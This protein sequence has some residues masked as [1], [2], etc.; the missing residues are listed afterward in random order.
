MDGQ[1]E[2][3]QVS[4]ERNQ[5]AAGADMVMKMDRQTGTWGAVRTFLSVCFSVGVMALAS[6]SNGTT[7]AYPAQT[8]STNPLAV[9]QLNGA[10]SL[11]HDPTIIR[12][13]STYYVLSTD[14]GTTNGQVG[15]LPILCSTDQI[16]WTR[17]GQV[18]N[19]IPSWI[20]SQ[21]S[22]ISTLWAPDVS[23]FNGLYHVYYVAS[24]FGTN[25]SVIGLATATTM[26]GP[27]TDYGSAI[28]QSTSSSYYNAIDPN[29]L[30]D[31]GS[32]TT[33]QHVW[34]TFGSFYGGIYQREINPATGTLLATNTTMYQLA[35]RPAVSGNPIEGASLVQKNGYYY[36][37][38]SFGYCCNS[39][40]TTDTYQI[41]VGRGSSPNGPFADENG[42]S[43]LQGG[44]TVILSSGGEFTAPGGESVYTDATNGD[45]IT[46]HALSN[47]QNGLDYLFVNQL[48]WPN[49]WPLIG[50][51]P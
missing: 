25:T 5:G 18:F 22:G 21:F 7:A 2:G 48:T 15:D 37:F 28:L 9:Y 29:I 17:C 31:Y 6:C 23:Y 30:V 44:G 51:A 39:N 14:P 45:L 50:T 38:V 34:L 49:N 42:T 1:S 32:G 12:E 27:W 3:F 36:L 4:E 10:V 46:F 11:V 26:A 20:Q 16:N 35:T 33:V 19:T 47:N 24:N 13:G 41:A 8:A 43:M 40:Y